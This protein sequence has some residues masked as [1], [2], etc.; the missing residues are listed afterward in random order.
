MIVISALYLLR[1]EHFNTT[2]NTMAEHR[3]TNDRAH[4]VPTE[5]AT[6]SSSFIG[7]PVQRMQ[8]CTREV[9]SKNNV[10]RGHCERLTHTEYIA[11]AMLKVQ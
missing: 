9:L 3:I 4:T 11:H 6:V 8:N 5:I 7:S 10:F 1:H 2:P